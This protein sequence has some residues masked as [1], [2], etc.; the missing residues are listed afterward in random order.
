MADQNIE[1]SYN[2]QVG[3]DIGQLNVTINP[4]E[5]ANRLPSLLAQIVPI[6]AQKKDPE[7]Q[8]GLSSYRSPHI[9]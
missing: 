4:S 1:G 5:L 9:G 6:L 3:G 8:N 7:S 2:I